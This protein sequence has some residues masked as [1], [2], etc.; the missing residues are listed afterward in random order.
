MAKLDF[1]PLFLVVLDDS[2]WLLT[3]DGAIQASFASPNLFL[4]ITP[5]II[6]ETLAFGLIKIMSE[7]A[8]KK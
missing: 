1:F 7:N 3:T 8:S 4:V 6:H 2:Y 5:L